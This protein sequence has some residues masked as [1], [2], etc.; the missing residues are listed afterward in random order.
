M[1]GN[2]GRFPALYGTLPLTAINDPSC[3]WI[4][5]PSAWQN[6]SRLKDTDNRYLLNPVPDDA[7]GLSLPG[8]PVRLSDQINDAR[9]AGT[10]ETTLYC[11]AWGRGM[12]FG[13]RG[14]LSTAISEHTGWTTGKMR[15]SAG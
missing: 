10:D 6:I 14:T 9:G 8:K 1:T 13:E 12:I 4:M 2:L 15:R 11:G 5:S 3:T 7:F